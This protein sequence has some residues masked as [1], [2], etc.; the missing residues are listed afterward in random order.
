MGNIPMKSS[1][2]FT[3]TL[4]LLIFY[5]QLQRIDSTV[6]AHSFNPSLGTLVFPLLTTVNPLSPDKSHQDALD[7]GCLLLISILLTD[8]Q[9]ILSAL[10]VAPALVSAHGH[11]AKWFIDGEEKAGF[12]PSYAAQY[13]P[14]AERPTDN[15]DQGKRR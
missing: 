13:G 10:L 4:S 1:S 15:S 11:V 12:N 2:S 3:F 6:D 7:R 5:S 8:M 9:T 14:T